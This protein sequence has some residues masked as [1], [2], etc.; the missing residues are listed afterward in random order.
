VKNDT[1]KSPNFRKIKIDYKN[2]I[3][4]NLSIVRFLKNSDHNHENS[5]VQISPTGSLIKIRQMG[6]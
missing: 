3:N 5:S 4:T 1:G 6:I 2:N